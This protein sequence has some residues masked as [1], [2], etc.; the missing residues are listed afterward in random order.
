MSVSRLERTKAGFTVVAE[1]DGSDF[2]GPQRVTVDGAE[3]GAR[4]MRLVGRLVDDM[5]AEFHEMPFVG[6]FQVMVRQYAEDR[7]AEL[8]A[9]E[10]HSGLLALHDKIDSSGR[11]EA[12]ATLAAAMRMPEET[13]RACLR[14]ARQRTSD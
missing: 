2:E 3:I 12:V 13:V 11:V 6:A 10:F 7:L 1:W 5:T 14:V 4:T 9:D 8:P